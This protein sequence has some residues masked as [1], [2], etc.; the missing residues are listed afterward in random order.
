[1]LRFGIVFFIVGCIANTSL[2]DDKVTCVSCHR[3]QAGEL[4]A[5]VHGEL[6]CQ[7]C[8]KG[9][10]SYTLSADRLQAYSA[11]D[12]RPPFD[13]GAEFAGK[14]ART[15]NPTLCGECH[16]DVERM[17]PYGLRVDQLA[18]Y[19]TS[20]HG[21]TLTQKGDDR[22]ATCLDCHGAHD[23]LPANHPKSKT[24]PLN[25]PEMCAACHADE[26]LMGEYDLPVEVVAEYKQ[27]V[28]GKLLLEQRDIGAPTC[29]TCH[30]NHSAVPP[31]FATV[32]KVCGQCHEH[33]EKNFATTIHAEQTEHKGCVQCHGGGDGRHFHLI[34]RITNPAGLMI[35]RYAHLLES[36][37]NPTPEQIT[38][39]I[40]PGP[41]TIIE[42]TLSTCTECHDE[43][44][45]DESLPKLFEV[46]DDIAEAE[47]YYV[48]TARRL[49]EVEQGV[50]LVDSQ[51]FK[52][53]DAKTH[54]IALA[55]LQHT[56]NNSVVAE[57]VS[58]LTDV[59]DE[60]NSEL[61]DL[62]RGLRWRHRALIP[63]WVFA[64]LFSG[65]LY[66]KYRQ[67]KSAYVKP[68]PPE[69]R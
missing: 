16:A 41:K 57:E 23:V 63:I 35:Q 9:S 61:D 12:G 36:V 44:D 3:Q 5:S 43:I 34:E 32:H 56:L 21:K 6:D 30:G 53:E 47:R 37:P 48:K 39:T 7:A 10:Q 49:D 14:P 26:K 22:V 68:L 59:C 62:E 46:L 11:T 25:V 20:Q 52:F 67:L 33:V 15:D 2:A 51:R 28:H 27:S 18:R 58:K 31:G 24:H 64:I 42:R 1:M 60:V 50:L 65:A 69:L 40:H 66:A 45:E 55:P 19:R 4:A 13:H 38:A 54:L 17:N 29:A 8:H